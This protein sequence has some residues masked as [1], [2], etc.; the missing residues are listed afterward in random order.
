MKNSFLLEDVFVEL[1][2]AFDSSNFQDQSH[3]SNGKKRISEYANGIEKFF[4]FYKRYTNQ[5]ENVYILDNTLKDKSFLDQEI[6][7]KTPDG[8]NYI[9]SNQNTFGKINKG[10]GDIEGWNYVKEI[11]KKYKYIFHYEPR[12]IMDSP[13]FIESFLKNKDNTFLKHPS[14]DTQFQTGAFLIQ[15]KDMIDYLNYRSAKSL[16]DNSICIEN[17]LCFFFK[18]FKKNKF[19]LVSNSG[20]FRHDAKTGYHKY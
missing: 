11:F 5:Y 9:F 19:T 15:S 18:K 17:D 8:V 1:R 6:L 16:S 4:N 3:V 12:L 20:M 2:C 13:I 7:N 10:A 14:L